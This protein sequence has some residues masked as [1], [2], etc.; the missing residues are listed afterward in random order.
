VPQNAF[1]EGTMKFLHRRQFLHLA[2]GAAALPTVSR[3]ANAQAIPAL[4]PPPPSQKA[5]ERHER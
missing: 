4:A 2:A 5:A 3:I 1:W